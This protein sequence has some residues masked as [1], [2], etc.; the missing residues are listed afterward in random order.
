M[1]S[2]PV[3]ALLAMLPTTAYAGN[4]RHFE[5]GLAGGVFFADGLEVLGTGPTVVPRI[6]YFIDE[7]LAIEADLGFQIGKTQLAAPEPFNETA[8][9]PRIGLLGRVVT[10]VKEHRNKEGDLIPA[11][12][13]PVN[14][15]LGMG[16]GVIGKSVDDGGALDLPT[17]ENL[18]V[19]FLGAFGPGLLVPVGPIGLRTDLRCL[20]SLGTEN[21]LNHGD[22][23]LN[24]EW[25]AGI[26]VELGGD[27]DA[28]D[29]GI[30][31]EV[32]SCIDVAEDFDQFEDV[33]GCPEADNDKDGVLDAADMAPNDPEDKDGFSDEDGKPE[34]D[35][36]EDGVLD[37]DD[38]CPVVKG[39]IKTEGCP[40]QDD[41]G[42]VD[43]VDECETE[44]GPRTSF[45]CPDGDAD[46]VPDHRDACPTE[47]AAAKIDPMKS[48]GCPSRVY[49][50]ENALVIT[51]KINFASGKSVIDKKSFSLLDDIVKVLVKY[52]G[53]KKVSVEGHT[54]SDG[55]DDANL[56][57][58]QA[59]VE[60]V[61]KYLTDKGID[62]ARLTAKGFGETTPIAPNDTP[63]GK[64][65]NHRVEFKILEQDMSQG[66]KRKME[67]KV[68]N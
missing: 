47:P 17:G 26:M 6:G 7:N 67:E 39:S 44:P 22:A 60:A 21:F 38:R 61:V 20:L 5:F 48:D 23:F 11:K 13:S 8:F 1:K 53:V 66:F 25:T 29:D 65:Q 14:L 46:R 15:L 49:F 41:D 52:P 18:D 55:M 58:S 31:D 19:D 3:L 2:L 56:K 28:D 59:R 54:D 30:D 4:E 64:G 16:I 43:S 50:E 63:D 12:D 40:D 57:L 34:P 51:E 62:A 37:A 27:K 45:G 36:D 32:D 24:W 68:G 33:D 10:E 42:L 35:N 9:T